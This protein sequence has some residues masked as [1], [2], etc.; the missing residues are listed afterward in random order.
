MF[1]M[2][3]PKYLWGEAVLTATYLINRMPSRVLGFVSPRQKLLD[4]FPY[5][6]L[7][8]EV[9]LKTF[10]C[11][12]YVYIQS[13]FRGKLDRRS[14][15]CVFLGY[16]G[17]Q[18][19]YKCFC[20]NTR[21]MYITL[22]VIF[23]ENTTYFASSMQSHVRFGQEQYWR[24]IDISPMRDNLTTATEERATEDE[25]ENAEEDVFTKEGSQT[26]TQER[27]RPPITQVYSRRKGQVTLPSDSVPSIK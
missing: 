7:L 3:V 16:S 11:V 1:S 13:Q 4:A 2:E 26:A 21:K 20:P 27:V 18:K 22:D 9:P 19:G 10:G 12:A 5:C 6:L 8:P 15:K 24:I 23:D 25:N 17:S 14:I